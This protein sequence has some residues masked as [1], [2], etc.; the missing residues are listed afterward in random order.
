MRTP[1]HL[2]S[3]RWTSLFVAL[4]V[5]S[6]IG[7]GDADTTDPDNDQ[8]NDCDV[9][10]SIGDVRC[11]GDTA[12]TCTTVDGC[13]D[14][15][16]TDECGDDEVCDGG[17]CVDDDDENGDECDDPCEEGDTRCSG[18]DVETCISV[19]GCPVWT[20]PTGCD[21]DKVCS[22]GECVDECTD[23][24]DDG[25]TTCDGDGVRTCEEQASGCLD[26][27]STDPC[28][29]GDVCDDGQ[30]VD[31]DDVT[32]DCDDGDT[33]CDGDDI[34]ECVDGQW[35]TTDS[36][37]DGCDDAQCIDDDDCDDGDTRCS[38]DET[39]VEEC[40]DGQWETNQSCPVACDDAECVEVED[41][42]PGEYRC[43]G[44]IVEIC[45]ST[46]SGFLYDSSCTT[47]CQDGQCVGGCTP[48]DQRCNGDDLEVCNDDGTA[49]EIDEPCDTTCDSTI[50]ECAEEEL[51][52]SSEMI[53]DDPVVVDG[54]V[55][56]ESGGTLTAFGGSID[57]R[58]HS[59]TVEDG[60][61]IDIA[62]RGEN[63]EG[64][65]EQGEECDCGFQCTNYGGG[66]GGSYNGFGQNAPCNVSAGSPYHDADYRYVQESSP[67]GQ[68]REGNR[69]S[70]GGGILELRADEIDIAGDIDVSGEDAIVES[71]GSD[72]TCWQHDA[73]GG[74]A[75]GSAVI[76]ADYLTVSG[77][78]DASGGDGHVCQPEND[79]SS[80][81]YSGDGGSGIIKLLY[82]S[83]Y[84]NTGTLAGDAQETSIPPFEIS[85]T[86]HP[87]ED[88]YY[89]DDFDDVVLA[90]Q[91][92]YAS[93][94]SYYQRMTTFESALPT[95]SNADYNEEETTVYPA[96]EISA[97]DNYFHIVTNDAQGNVGE[98]ASRY[99]I[100]INS[101]PPTVSSSSHSS[102]THWYDNDTIHLEWSDPRDDESL[103]GY[104]Y[105]VDQYGDT[106]PTQDDTYK[107]IDEKQ[108]ILANQDDGVWAF[109]IIAVDTMDYPTRES[110][111]FVFRI[112]EDPGTGNIY[113][114]IDNDGGTVVEDARLTINRGLLE[115][116]D[117]QWTDDNGNY[118]FGGD[119]PAGDWELQVSADGYETEVVDITLDDDEDKA[120]D[121]T[122]TAE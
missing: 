35:E 4:A 117:D 29:S 6:L 20:D 92:P 66:A 69:G 64:A 1:E 118:N 21:G 13:P 42:D 19:D 8:A 30:C 63:P 5:V 45:N 24:C 108:D 25:E 3:L 120:V 90:W 33:Q 107:P 97:G 32:D 84:D 100:D 73:T 68:D 99:N 11:D 62:P 47:D 12:E 34:E 81:H 18:T 89:N 55:T 48:G 79:I 72:S 16:V 14:W 109:H 103:T 75:G 110:G 2:R 113:G 41:C 74:G 105:T 104:Y 49:W 85:S 98:I 94:D 114:Q 38:G 15:T 119:V 71:E 91:A 121:V 88:L 101:E 112:G 82:G 95:P 116:V 26:W 70:Y 27:S 59:I 28:D 22:G 51:T 106:V 93:V 80:V 46:G 67:G 7:C 87:D 115:E 57:I 61:A 78:I 39:D 60:G 50:Y 58:A 9:D 56:V 44:N 17:Q 77:T 65:G 52:V 31:E 111:T 37:P 83:D 54:P 76:A 43:S 122:L 86:T 40:V 36:C 96:E 10:C 102:E 23:Q 53:L